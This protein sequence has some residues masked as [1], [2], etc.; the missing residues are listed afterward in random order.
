LKAPPQEEIM[1]PSACRGTRIGLRLLLGMIAIAMVPTAAS[2]A[3]ELLMLVPG[4]PGSSM[5]AGHSGW[6]NAISFA[7]SAVAPATAGEVQPCQVVVQKQLDIASP[8]LWVATVT[9]RIFSSPIRIQVLTA[10]GAAGLYVLYD[11]ELTNAEITSITD[12]GSNG[13]PLE[14]V[15]LKAAKATVT[16]NERNPASGA[17]TPIT[18]SF[19]CA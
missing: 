1:N 10:S 6:I 8:H 12:S 5:V 19:T 18:T 4:I 2:A 16:F 11:V 9:G 7:G 14:T 13:L 3:E 15:T 17:L